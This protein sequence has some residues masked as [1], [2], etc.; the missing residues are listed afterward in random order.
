MGRRYNGLRLIPILKALVGICLIGICYTVK[1]YRNLTVDP[2]EWSN[3]DKFTFVHCTSFLLIV[4]ITYIR[5]DKTK[6]NP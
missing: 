4:T 3:N 1:V 5:H 2:F 6:R